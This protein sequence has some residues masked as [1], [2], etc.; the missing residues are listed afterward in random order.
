MRGPS[1]DELRIRK[2]AEKQCSRPRD[3]NRMTDIFKEKG[4]E[5]RTIDGR[6]WMMCTDE[7]L[8]MLSKG[9]KE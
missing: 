4:I 9:V 1:K 2:V 7:V 5:Y 3:W 8:D 6:T